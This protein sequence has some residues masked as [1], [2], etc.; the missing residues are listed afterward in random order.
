[1]Q[2]RSMAAWQKYAMTRVARCI[3]RLSSVLLALRKQS[4]G[5]RTPF[6]HNL[7]AV[8]QRVLVDGRAHVGGLLVFH[9]AQLGPANIT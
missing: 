1:M 4:L 3:L 2:P 7:L 5:L 8:R 6:L 9:L